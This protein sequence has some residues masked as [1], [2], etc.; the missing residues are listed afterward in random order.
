MYLSVKDRYYLRIKGWNKIFQ[1][2][3]QKKE[4]AIDI[5]ILSKIDFQI[6]GIKKNNE[7]TSY[8]SKGKKSTN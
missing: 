1:E 6:E 7:N 8:S 4:A 2:S 3:D 5:L